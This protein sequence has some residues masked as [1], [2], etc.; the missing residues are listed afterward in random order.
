MRFDREGCGMMDYPEYNG[1]ARELANKVLD[2]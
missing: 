2:K 1:K